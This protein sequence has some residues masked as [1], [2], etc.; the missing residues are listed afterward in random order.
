MSDPVPSSSARASEDR[1]NALLQAAVDGMVLIDPRGRITRF[2]RAAERL[3]GYSADEVLGRN[4][5]MLMPA[6]YHEEHDGYIERYGRTGEARIIGI[7]REVVGR[8]KD[9]STFP[10]ELSVGEFRRAP[11]A[12]GRRTGDHDEH[13]FVGILRDISARRAQEQQLIEATEELRRA[14]GEAEDLRA[15]LTHAGRLG[16]LGE[17]VSGI[18]H[19]VNQPLTAIAT[20]ASAC[21]RLLLS[22]Q[23]QPQEL[24]EVLDKISTQAERAGQVIR[25][26]RKLARRQDQV[27]VPLEVNVLVSEVARLLEFEFRNAGFELVQWLAPDLP[28]VLGDGVQI[29]QVVLNLLRN[30]VEAMAESASSDTVELITR[31]RGD[32]VEICVEDRGPGLND[33]GLQRLFEPFHTTKPQG[34]GLGLS[35]C[36]SIISSHGG[37][38]VHESREGG[39]ARFRISLRAGEMNE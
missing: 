16:S 22:G 23:A 39:G 25:G 35:I 17:M 7:G 14:F 26:L 33:S 9:G 15:R 12:G 27:S 10:L 8:R 30:A 29:Q 6:P 28:T 3:F 31:A 37:E 38:L 5:S 20:Y 19:E 32:H 24:A 34:M 4:V 11:V 21:K 2:N 1:L 13:G 36:K 18:A